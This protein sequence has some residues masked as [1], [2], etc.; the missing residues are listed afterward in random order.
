MYD[1]CAMSL[2]ACVQLSQHRERGK[3]RRLHTSQTTVA[4][5]FVSHFP[6]L[7]RKEEKV[8]RKHIALRAKY[9]QN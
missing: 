4:Y 9:P 8:A 6:P 2:R 3:A 1:V 7:S 5:L